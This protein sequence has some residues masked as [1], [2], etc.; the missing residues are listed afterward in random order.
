MAEELSTW[1]AAQFAAHKVLVEHELDDAFTCVCG[2]H[3]FGGSH[4][5]H[6]VDELSKA[7]AFGG[8]VQHGSVEQLMSDANEPATLPSL[9]ELGQ[10]LAEMAAEHA[11]CHI[12]VIDG[13]LVWHVVPQAET[14]DV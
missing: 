12:E 9:R 6:L 13:V 8:P 1:T 2:W 3:Q 10:R 14:G 7:G 11:P 5:S 4:A